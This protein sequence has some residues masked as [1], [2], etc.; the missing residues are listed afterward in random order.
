MVERLPLPAVLYRA[1]RRD[2]PVVVQLPVESA[3]AARTLRAPALDGHLDR[4]ALL[5]LRKKK[6][7]L[8][9]LRRIEVAEHRLADAP[10]SAGVLLVPFELRRAGEHLL[11]RGESL[12]HLHRREALV[13]ELAAEA[14]AIL[15]VRVERTVLMPHLPVVHVSL[16]VVL[17]VVRETAGAGA[18]GA[19]PEHARRVV[20]RDHGGLQRMALH[21]RV[22]V[23]LRVG[24]RL[25]E[26]LERPD[27][28]VVAAPE[29]DRGVVPETAQLMRKLALHLGEESVVCRIHRAREPVVVPD[30]EAQL[31]ADVVERVALVLPAAPEAHHVHVRR[32]RARKEV[33]VA[34]RRLA[35]LERIARNP[36][37]ALHEKPAPVHL[38]GHSTARSV[39]F[40]LPQAYA[41]R[42]RLV[43]DAYGVFVELPLPRSV[44]PPKRR[45]VDRDQVGHRVDAAVRL[46]HVGE[47]RKL[48]AG[49]VVVEGLRGI[50]VVDLRAVVRDEPDRAAE[51]CR[52]LRWAPVPPGVAGGLPYERLVLRP[53]HVRHREPAPEDG[54]AAVRL[55]PRAFEDGPYLVPP[56]LHG[57]LRVKRPAR[58][59]V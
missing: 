30:E 58:E 34:L 45:V 6:L 9:V 16:G 46:R 50:D 52:H 20:L 28:F 23:V 32:H 15:V 42:N 36:V 49:E 39:D 59:A 51:A 11:P 1:P 35:R 14:R 44:R 19:R 43:A 4:H 5:E 8:N 22:L 31:V 55:R 47:C 38:E 27:A 53:R 2:R 7:R 41:A 12:G 17:P 29:R 10:V 18:R 21:Q 37:R 3:H 57:L 40:E 33:A 24:L 13:A 25:G 26:P 56:G 54:G 48:T